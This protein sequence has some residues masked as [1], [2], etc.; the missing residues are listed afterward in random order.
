MGLEFVAGKPA[1]KEAAVDGKG[2]KVV[3]TD[4]LVMDM[5]S[6]FGLGR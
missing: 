2:D 1:D 6:S 5:H 3:R 4:T